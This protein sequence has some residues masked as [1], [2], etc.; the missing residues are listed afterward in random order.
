MD[1]EKRSDATKGRLVDAAIGVIA[2]RGLQ[3]ASFAEICRRCDLS[4]G[5]IHHHYASLPALLVDVVRTIGK[6]IKVGAFTGIDSLG[7]DQ[8]VYE[9][10]I[11]YVWQQMQTPEFKALSQIRSAVGVD[12]SL[13]GE[14]RRELRE[15]HQ[16]WMEQANNVSGLGSDNA[17]PQT[18]M[19]ILTALMGTHLIDAAM[20]PPEEDR[21]RQAYR[22]KLKDLVLR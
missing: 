15:V 21:D 16:W 6:R 2:E 14:V 9:Y 10:G 20:G 17:D 3:G 19:I 13:Q 4:R 5:A 18:T 22:A 7:P 11:D 8:D 12:E 1:N